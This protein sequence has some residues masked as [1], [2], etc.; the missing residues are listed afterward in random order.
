MSKL[1]NAP[2]QEVSVDFCEV[3]DSYLLVVIDDYSRYPEVQLLHSTS[4]KAVIPHL[5]HIFSTFGIPKV[6]RSDNG[7]PFK[8]AEVKQFAAHLGFE[9]RKITPRLS[10]ANGEAE[11]FM[12]T[13]KKA[14]RTAT[15]LKQELYSF[16]RN[17]RATPHSTTGVPPATAL[18]GRPLRTR[19]PEIPDPDDSVTP[20]DQ[21]AMQKTDSQAKSKMKLY[22]DT[23]RNA[24]LSPIKLGDTVLVANDVKGKLTPPFDPRPLIIVEKKGSMLTAADHDK[25]VTRNSSHFKL[26]PEQGTSVE[27]VPTS[28]ENASQ[29]NAAASRSYPTRVRRP[30]CRFQ[31]QCFDDARQSNLEFNLCS[32]LTEQ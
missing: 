9:D 7:P 14:F 32:L 2:W 12:R 17:Y 3:E 29:K 27:G 18:F 11:R 25:T 24:T 16:L 15:A 10:E 31:D 28:Q 26:L 4:A 13:L 19:L 6:L 20:F 21:E 5:D 8:S 23:T 30:P 1:P 22:A